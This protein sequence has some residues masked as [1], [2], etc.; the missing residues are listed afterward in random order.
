MTPVILRVRVSRIARMAAA[1]DM[2]A[3]YPNRTV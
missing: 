2:S 3:E 1:F